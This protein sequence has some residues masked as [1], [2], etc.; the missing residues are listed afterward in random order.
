MKRTLPLLVVLVLGVA[1]AACKDD[2]SNDKKPNTPAAGGDQPGDTG[3]PGDPNNPSTGGNP[4]DATVNPTEGLEPATA[5][6]EA[7][8][9]TDGPVWHAGMGVLFFTTPLGE[10]ALYRMLPDGRVLKVRDGVAKDGTQPIGNTVDPNGMVITVEA[11]QLV[12][13]PADKDAVTVLATG[14]QGQD[15]GKPDPLNP[16]APPPPQTPG[17]F[18]TLNDVIARKDGTMYM[19]DPGY[20]AGPDIKANRIYRVTPDH[21]VQ[22]VEAFEDIPRPNG[23]ALTPDQKA[24]YVGFSAPLQGTLPFVRKY[25]VNDD[26]TLG[27]WAKFTDIGP[28]DSAPDGMAVDS[29]GNLYVAA[30]NGPNVGVIQVYK[31]DGSQWGT[32]PVPEVPTGLTFGGPDLKTLYVTTGGVKIW[33]LKAKITGLQK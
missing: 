15:Q 16:N 17:A 26:G 5:I 31:P 7:G 32:I 29:V 9:F 23:L 6:L 19:T 22:T 14:Y 2:S 12:S 33:Q 24:L 11:K 30:S 3:N 1:A 13:S 18:D 28:Q 21:K 27:E 25:V 8:A 10:G 20:F 4:A